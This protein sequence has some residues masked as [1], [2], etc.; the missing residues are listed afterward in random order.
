MKIMKKILLSILIGIFI[1]NSVFTIY[2]FVMIQNIKKE[3]K[4]YYNEETDIQIKLTGGQQFIDKASRKKIEINYFDAL[5]EVEQIYREMQKN[6]NF[7][8]L[9]INY[10]MERYQYSHLMDAQMTDN[11]EIKIIEGRGF[12]QQEIDDGFKGVIVSQAIIYK[13]GYENPLKLGD[14]IVITEHYWDDTIEKRVYL[15]SFDLEIIGIYES[16]NVIQKYSNE[17]EKNNYIYVPSSVMK[18]I[19]VQWDKDG[20]QFDDT[21]LDLTILNPILICSSEKEYDFLLEELKQYQSKV[22]F[23]LDFFRIDNHQKTDYSFESKINEHQEKMSKYGVATI[24]LVIPMM[25]IFKIRY[26]NKKL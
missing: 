12:T 7:K 3:Y 18:E 15:T 13:N 10:F 24:I 9:E 21:L 23:Q 2:H 6:E 11:N 14:K 16:P 25:I 17:Y 1:I 26:F 4:N 8:D 22:S 5:N 20:S 19:Q